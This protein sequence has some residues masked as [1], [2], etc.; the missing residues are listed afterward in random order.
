[1][2]KLLTAVLILFICQYAAA[3]SDRLSVRAGANLFVLKSEND[4]TKNY[5]HGRVGYTF[6]AGFELKI[7]KSF[8]IQ[9]ELNYSYQEAR[10]EYHGSTLKVNYTQVP[11][12]LRFHPNNGPV[13]F[14]AG[15][16]VSFLGSAK[17]SSDSG[18]DVGISGQ[19]NQTDVGIGWGIATSPNRKGIFFDLRIYNGL[20]D[21]YKA[22]YDNGIKTRP[23][24]VSAY[25][26]Y[27]FHKK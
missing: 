19:L 23:L 13:V 7:N 2:R 4:K 12:L 17:T 14:Y 22:E 21:V 6:G 5:S 26:G 3:Q 8:S 25:I 18:P 15:P 24:L 9:P 10:E 20:M 16:Q 11:V 27:L 1:M